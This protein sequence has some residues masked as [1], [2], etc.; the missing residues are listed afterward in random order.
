MYT[1][2]M[3]YFTEGVWNLNGVAQLA[4]PFEIHTPPVEGIV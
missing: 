2:Q 1:I 3:K 4:N